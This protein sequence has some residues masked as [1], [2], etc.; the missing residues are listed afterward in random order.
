M[1]TTANPTPAAMA[2]PMSPKAQFGNAFAQESATTMKVLRAFP[3]GAQELR[4]HERCRS[5][6]EMAHTF[7]IEQ[8][9]LAR[10]LRDELTMPPE[11]PEPVGSWDDAVHAIE[12]VAQD[13]LAALDSA[14][15][16]LTGA[17]PFFTGPGQMG[18]VPK[19]QFAW[20]MLCDQIHH[21]GQFS[22]YLRMAGGKVPSIYGP[23]AD[24]PWM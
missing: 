10:A 2:P 17:V 8:L 11:L 13:V 22:I 21:R 5:A 6:I 19:G 23:S 3:A 9:M 7:Y 20:M 14:D 15:D 4:P 16:A 24:E 18:D 12:Q 1:S